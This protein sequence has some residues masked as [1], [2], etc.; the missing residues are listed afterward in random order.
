LNGGLITGA[1]DWLTL[2][3]R[4]VLI[5]VV[6]ESQ[7]VYWM[8]L[9]A[10]PNL[11]LVKIRQLIFSFLWSGCSDRKQLHLCRWEAIA[12]PKKVGGW[13]LRNLFLFNKALATNTLWR[14]LTKTGIW[15]TVI[16]DKYLPYVS[17]ATWFRSVSSSQVSASQTW[18][19]FLKRSSYWPLVM[20]ETGQW[21]GDPGRQRLYSWSG[22][23]V[24]LIVR[25]YLCFKA[26]R[27]HL[28]I[29]GTQCSEANLFRLL[30]ER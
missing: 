27:Y 16:K 10:V 11:V 30:L 9:A 6:L 29:S 5:K 1:T 21:T 12:K 18:K 17:V 4:F 23:A 8:T 20:L 14:V 2:G 22:K 28:L 19:I 3:G 25:T 26:T 13:G 7:P 15:H 24:H